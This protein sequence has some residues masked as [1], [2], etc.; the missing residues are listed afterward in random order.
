MAALRI[1]ALVLA[2]LVGFQEEDRDPGTRFFAMPMSR[3]ARELAATAQEHLMA[4]RW[5]E[6]IGLLQSLCEEH[7]AEVLPQ[8]WRQSAAQYS[9]FAAHPGAG[10]WA[11]E[12]L[13]ALPEE[14][15]ELYRQRFEP[16]AAEALE[17]ALVSPERSALLAV[18]RRWPIAPSAVRAWRALGDLELER[19]AADV[20]RLAWQRAFDLARVLELPSTSGDRAR[21]DWLVREA[22]RSAAPPER[23]SPPRADAQPWTRLLELSPFSTRGGKTYARNA[24][25]PLLAGDRVLVSSTM[26]LFALDAFTGELLWTGGPPP[27][28]SALSPK[29]TNDLYEGMHWDQLLVAPAAGN[30]VALAALQTSFSE[31]EN[32]NWQGIHIMSAIPERRLFAFDLETG[33]PL[34][35]HAPPLTW[36]AREHRW[37]WDEARTPYPRRMMIAAPPTVSGSRV[38]VPCYRMQGRIDYHV[39]CY[40]L[41]TGELLWFTPVVSG[42]R[43]RNMFGRSRLEFAATPVIV[44]G[45]RVLAQT[46]LGTVAA[47]DLFTGRVL[48]QSLYR[49]TPLPKT[50]SY[51]IKPRPQTWRLAPPVVVGDLV[52][53]TPSDSDELV[54]IRVDDGRVLWAVAERTLERLDRSTAQLG[55]NL[56]L[57]AEGDTLYLSGQKLAAIQKPGGF[58]GSSPWKLR[59]VQPLPERDVSDSAPRPVLCADSVFVPGGAERTA[60]SRLTGEP[61]DQWSGTWNGGEAGNVWVSDDALFSVSGM[62]VS[63]YFD[64]HALLERTRVAAEGPA[65]PESLL[66]AAELFQR[67]G[68][69]TLETGELSEARECL[70]LARTFFE[71][72]RDAGE[73]PDRWRPGIFTCLRSLAEIQSLEGRADEALEL[74]SDARSAAPDDVALRDLLLQEE[75]LLRG[76]DPARRIAVL[77][78]LEVRVGSLP[79]PHDVLAESLSA[80]TGS[81]T[82]PREV[83]E[84]APITTG[85]WVL[86]ERAVERG[87]LGETGPALVDLTAALEHASALEDS[88]GVALTKLVRE[89]IARLLAQPDGRT[90][91]AP[92]EERAAALLEEARTSGDPH[93][94]EE[95]AR[96]FPHSRAAGSALDER[97][98]VAL[99]AD[100]VRTVAALASAALQAPEL[101]PE[102]GARIAL[103]LAHALG[104]AGNTAYEGSLYRALARELPD[105]VSDVAEHAGKTTTQLAAD[106]PPEEVSAPA[107]PV[108]FDPAVLPTAREREG[109]HEFLGAIPGLRP[110]EESVPLERHVYAGRDELVAFSSA[111]PGVPMWKHPWQPSA[112]SPRAVFTT[113]R[114]YYAEREDVCCI[115]ENGEE[116]WRATLAEGPA[117]G[118]AVHQGVLVALTETGHVHA[119]DATGGIPLWEA[120]LG[121]SGNWSGPLC[122]SARAVFFSQLH[123]LPP[124]ARVFDLLR[125]RSVAEF[126]L[127]GLDAAV[128]LE[129]TAW[130]AGERLI[131]PA[132]QARPTH[133]SA[134]DLE[135]GE[136]VWHCEFGRDE[137]LSSVVLADGRSF[138][139]TLPSRPTDE[140]KVGEN[141]NG[142]IYELD[143]AGGALRR[144]V[145]VKGAD[146][147]MGLE[148]R[149]RVEL[150]AP[151]VFL[152]SDNDR[153]ISIRAIHLPYGLSWSY[154]LPVIGQELYDGMALPMPAVSSECVAIAYQTRRAG[155]TP[156]D[157]TSIVFVDKGD[158]KLR[159]TLLLGAREPGSARDIELRGLGDALFVL[160][161]GSSPRGSRL[162]ILEKTR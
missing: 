8:E 142:G 148:P 36:D 84:P 99:R 122:S 127:I 95:V 153:S 109:V 154:S 134:F 46:E 162:A 59:W 12:Q 60:Y 20:A 104:R 76:R 47:L 18:A 35:D 110:S 136:R 78:E 139:V 96:R 94:L 111:A 82:D 103:R 64:W 83:D 77:D 85:L 143:V 21:E 93:A 112:R 145:P 61:L 121:E 144:V 22:E 156:M 106:G 34:W 88:A 38:F 33:R 89:R 30:N 149:T 23:R 123:N 130:I 102:R 118:L 6:G 58:T 27:G 86:V 24:L 16:I 28:W 53:C 62:G 92:F 15:R 3:G 11:L 72:L 68:T 138:V 7:G 97:M 137:E 70:T 158:G 32:Q 71:R 74:L 98:E 67:R 125:G 115:D 117:R 150:S 131:A 14:A 114:M 75:H 132:F 159:D 161:R 50:T 73:A 19:G 79:L 151:Y 42:Q 9:Q 65:G 56:L 157:E 48:W 10:E 155:A 13:L 141:R 1:T 45:D 5:S 63:G 4:E 91:Y 37:T 120:H 100:D 116:L 2:T 57:G 17:H 25:T 31:T 44:T 52:L 39:A 43:E 87:R 69:L 29:D 133:V 40:E 126:P 147:P 108:T 54:A 49:Q 129:E 152:F 119:F 105:L 26:R 107:A 55:F 128:P 80:W 135:R 90:A 51:V 81:E 113:G 66:S 160:S 41:E 124:R 146:R 140:S 101:E